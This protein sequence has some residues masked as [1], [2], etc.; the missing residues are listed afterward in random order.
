M[1]RLRLITLSG[2]HFDEDVHEAMIPTQA[3]D[4]AIYGGH[5]S[6]LSVAAPGVVAIRKDRKVKDADREFVA[7]YGGTVEVLD[8]VITVLVDEVDD[9]SEVNEAEAQKAHQRALEMKDKAKDALSLQEAQKLIDRSSVR[10]K[11]AGLK[12]HSHRR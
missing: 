6:L 9:T 7:I 11:L 1:I 8:N 12:K 10:L 4:I 5:A 3:G 2:V